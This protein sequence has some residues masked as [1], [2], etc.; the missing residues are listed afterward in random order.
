MDARQQWLI[1]KAQMER[2]PAPPYFLTSLSTP[3]GGRAGVVMGIND[4]KRTAELLV[5]NS[6]RLSTPAEIEQHNAADAA[7]IKF[8]ADTETKNK[9]QMAMPKELQDLVAVTLANLADKDK[10]NK[11]DKEKK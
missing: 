8:Y 10:D 1:V 4:P 3:D 5:A 11:K 6:H 2:L 7:A 9:Q